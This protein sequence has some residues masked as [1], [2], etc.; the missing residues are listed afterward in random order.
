MKQQREKGEQVG[1]VSLERDVLRLELNQCR[2]GFFQER[3]GEDIHVD[4]PKMEKAGEPIILQLEA[5]RQQICQGE[6]E[7]VW[8]V[9]NLSVE[10]NFTSILMPRV[11]W[12]SYKICSKKTSSTTL[13]V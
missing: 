1:S 11:Y 5:G 2:E 13:S 6:T 12:L 7:N 3:E 4:R 9:I 10:M 8:S